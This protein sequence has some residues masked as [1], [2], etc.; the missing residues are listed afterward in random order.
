MT[1]E[2]NTSL[3]G[4]DL[5]NTIL[6]GNG[7]SSLWGGNAGNDLLIGGA[8]KNTFFYTNGNGS[9][10][11]AGANNGDVVYLSQVTLEQ[12]ASSN[13]TAD[14]VTLNFK[15][16]GSL[17]VNS[18]ADI[19]YQLADGSKFSANHAQAVWLLKSTTT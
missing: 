3:V 12:I 7:D 13:I 4:N 6:A 17:Q 10:T 18:N 2:G 5:D 9:D 11:I 1:A 14:A 8:G 16:G 15:D 19:T